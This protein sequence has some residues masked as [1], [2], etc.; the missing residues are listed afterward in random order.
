VRYLDVHHMNYLRYFKGHNR[1]VLH[2]NMSPKND[3]FLTSSTVRGGGG[4]GG[5]GGRGRRRQQRWRRSLM[6]PPR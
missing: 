5:S 6:T 1:E 4:A 2:I 3:A